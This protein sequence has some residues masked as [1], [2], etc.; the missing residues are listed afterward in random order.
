MLKHFPIILILFLTLAM[1]VVAQPV[2]GQAGSGDALVL[3]W[4]DNIGERETLVACSGDGR[5]II[6]GSDTG[7]LR[8]YDRN[9]AALWTFSRQGKSV[10]SVAI[11]G[12]GDYAGAVFINEQGP[13]SSANGEVVFF[14]RNGT[15]LWNTSTD[16]TVELIRMSD[17]SS[18]VYV[19][20]G[21][22][23]LYSYSR[24]GTKLAKN[25][26]DGRIWALDSARDGSYAAA[27]SQITGNH[28][29]VMKKDGVTAWN[30]STK[31]GFGSVDI[32]PDGGSVAAAGYSHLYSFDR[33]GTLLW[34]YNGSSDFTNV[35]ISTDGK[36]TAAGSQ[37][38]ARLFSRNGSI[39][40]TH[41]YEGFVHDVGISDDSDSVIVGSSQGLDI[42]DR[43]GN[44]L[45]TF[46]TP[47]A[48][49]HVSASR[50]A[51]I[52][53][54]GTADMVYVFSRG[55]TATGKNESVLPVRNVRLSPLDESL[56]GQLTP[57][58]SP[59]SAA[60]SPALLPVVGVSPIHQ[61]GPGGNTSYSLSIADSGKLVTLHSNNG[62]GLF[63]YDGNGSFLWSK[64]LSAEQPPW[65]SSVSIAPGAQDLIITQLVPA[66]CHGSVTN[67]SSNKVILLDRTGT[68]VWEYPTMNP[69]LASGI[70]ASGQDFFIGT[71]DGRILCLDR[72]GTVRWTT[73][74]EA[75]VTSFAIS[76][77]GNTIVATG[78]S[79][80]YYHNL[81]DEPLNPA[82]IFVLDRN[83]TLL[84]NYQTGG[85]NAVAVSDDGS[86]IAVME[87]RSGNVLVFNRSGSRVMAK[88][89]GGV[90][91]ALVL[92]HDGNLIVAETQG[93][94]V[95][96]LDRTGA[97]L[98]TITAGPGS[99]GIAFSGDD[100]SIILGRGRS[101]ALFDSRGKQ[102][103]D[104]PA[105]GP[106]Q[107]IEPA[108]DFRMFVAGTDRS[109]VFISQDKTVEEI[110]MPVGTPVT[111]IPVKALTQQ[112]S[113]K[114]PVDP[115]IT[116]LA[117]AGNA[118]AIIMTNSMY[119]RSL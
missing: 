8:M 4:S 16:P 95:Y 119:T 19:S 101:V 51:G 103:G 20:A 102:L 43:E 56:P 80:Y 90:S 35:A 6:V 57:L 60:Q 26:S 10:R 31:I 50:D 74:V 27:G 105:D 2:S 11:S 58:Q 18:S 5:Y 45:W 21:S 104:Y 55:G 118:L 47:N 52:F 64:T 99:Q 113:M 111:I 53:A 13:S 30:Y 67:T 54:A 98:W 100:N 89:L 107:A 59:A 87:E 97:T 1:P 23:T 77:D 85:L 91:S 76:R 66:C 17:D 83:G 12:S 81:Y 114:A 71:E 37:Y 39:I 48:I 28:L 79:N 72:N 38:Y 46:S 115:V 69:P 93:G 110:E 36:Y 106:V 44:L 7:I 40:W 24:Y 3:L 14:D 109:L 94:T 29:M 112:T 34:Q 15:V 117:L 92:S 25:S 78:E 22:G 62:P 70:S 42:F 96:G 63:A 82:D 116:I 61:A 33:N 41:Q 75:P 73:P 84:W 9:G 88:S 108:R 65:I 32:S 49:V 86:V 68:K